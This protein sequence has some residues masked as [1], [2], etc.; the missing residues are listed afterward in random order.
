MF[1]PRRHRG[2]VVQ[3]GVDT[4]ALGLGL[5]LVHFVEDVLEEAVV[6]VAGYAESVGRMES[7]QEADRDQDGGSQHL[8]VVEEN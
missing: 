4:V 1:E 3:V 2:R 5:V 6:V 8:R 7:N